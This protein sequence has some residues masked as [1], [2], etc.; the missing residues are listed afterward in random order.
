MVPSVVARPGMTDAPP[1]PPSPPSPPGRPRRGAASTP[2]SRKRTADRKRKRAELAINH[3][4]L[5]GD[6]RLKTIIKGLPLG[7]DH[8]PTPESREMVF[9]LHGLGVPEVEIAIMIHIPAGTLRELYWQELD[10]AGP[11]FN[12]MAAKTIHDIATDRDHPK[13][14]EAAKFWCETRAGWQRTS[15]LAVKDTRASA[16]PVIDSSRLSPEKRDQLRA[17]MLEMA[18][19]DA[20]LDA[21]TGLAAADG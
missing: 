15:V 16:A 21:P 20:A 10:R 12:Y 14:F 17:L 4:L 19:E 18:G 11:A 6:A 13:A 9:Q 1:S 8:V 2:E 5:R 7:Q 3:A